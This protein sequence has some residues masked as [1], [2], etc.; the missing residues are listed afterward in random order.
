VPLPVAGTSPAAAE[1]L[2]H[3]FHCRVSVISSNGSMKHV[4]EV[5]LLQHWFPPPS[6][7]LI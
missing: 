6:T 5:Q 7:V 1:A 2:P 4:E 3:M